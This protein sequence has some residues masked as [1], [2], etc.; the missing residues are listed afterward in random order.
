VQG[1]R[2]WQGL[3]TAIEDL[4]VSLR[5][6]SMDEIEDRRKLGLLLRLL[7]SLVPEG[8]HFAQ[9]IVDL[10]DRTI[11]SATD[12]TA[13]AHM[14]TW[15]N[16]GTWNDA[17]VLGSILRCAEKLVFNPM[18]EEVFKTYLLNA[19]QLPWLFSMYYWNGEIMG[20][21]ASFVELWKMNIR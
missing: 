13:T 15:R 18:A 7:S 4:F 14:R 6:R 8:H 11:R 21:V 9:G 3:V 20:S 2:W 17:H 1:G 10:L 5:E 16:G 12:A 19:H